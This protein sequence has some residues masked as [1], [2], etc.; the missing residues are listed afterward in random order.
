MNR[1][2]A[3]FGPAIVK[4]MAQTGIGTDACMAKGCLP[5][6]IHFY[7]P[8]PDIDDLIRRDVWSRESP[9]T[10]I[11]FRPYEQLSLL[12]EL[13]RDYGDEC[14]W[15]TSGA[16]D[17]GDYFTENSCFGYGC[18]AGTHCMVRSFKPRRIIEIGSG[19]S[20][21]VISSALARNR[22]QGIST[23][24]TIVD[25]YPREMIRNGLNTAPHLIDKKV[26]LLDPSFFDQL[27]TN[28]ILFIDSSHTVRIGGDVNFLFLDVLPRLRP[29]VIV[30]IHDIHLPCE[31]HKI[32]ATNPS[33]RV[34]WTEA[35]LLQAFLCHNSD[36]EVLLAMTWIMTKHND[37]FNQAFTHY[38]PQKH[39]AISGGF[40]IRRK[41]T[42]ENN[43]TERYES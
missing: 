28:D 10:G 33:F 32:Y 16:I 31:Y 22:E 38:N 27:R 25:P 9:L 29:G 41:V 37:R 39:M 24:Y 2:I 4:Y 43:Q 8:I 1:L 34:F 23:D 13:G 14:D 11:D 7:Q 21:L 42:K 17:H 35:Y 5:V 20:S 36:W 19:Y 30:H 26:E 15:L 18:A 40:W 12:S 6:S 3:Q